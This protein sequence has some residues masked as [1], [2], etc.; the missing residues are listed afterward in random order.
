MG[1]K[2]DCFKCGKNL[3]ELANGSKIIKEGFRA[4]CITCQENEAN[5]VSKLFGGMF[6]K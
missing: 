2:I 4:F 1:R 6:K 3:A 5:D